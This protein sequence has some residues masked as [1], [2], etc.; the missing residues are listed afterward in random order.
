MTVTLINVL[1]V[2][3]LLHK[4]FLKMPYFK[5]TNPAGLKQTEEQPQV[6]GKCTHK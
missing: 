1:H 2:K 5:G 3:H 4:K 6:T